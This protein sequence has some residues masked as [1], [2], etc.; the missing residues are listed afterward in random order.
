M[1]GFLLS[2]SQ[3]NMLVP[4]PNLTIVIIQGMRGTRLQVNTYFWILESQ[5]K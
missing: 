1:H 5:L 2:D 4:I 3:K